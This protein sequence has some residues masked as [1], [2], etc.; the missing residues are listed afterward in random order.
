MGFSSLQLRA[1]GLAAHGVSPEQL[2]DAVAALLERGQD[3][4]A[5]QV[6]GL[7][8]SERGTA[9]DTECDRL[10]AWLSQAGAAV[11][12]PGGDDYP[13]HLSPLWPELG[14][15][16]WLFV[17]A[18][19]AHVPAGP[20]VAV[21]GSR[22][23][24]LEGRRV[25]RELGRELAVNG[26]TVVSGL[27]KGIDQ[28][29]H[30]GALD[31]EGA[32]VAVLGTGFDVDYPRGDIHLRKAI[33][34]SGGLVTEH[35]PGTPP[36]KHTFL[37]RNRIVAGLAD[38]TVV[39]EGG[40]QSGS[41]H[42]ARMAAAQGRDVWAVPGPLQAPNSQAPLALI[43]DGANVV[44]QLHDVVGAV[45]APRLELPGQ[46]ARGSVPPGNG[47]D[48]DAQTVHRL[49]SAVPSTPSAIAVAAGLPVPAVSAILA[50]L[51]DHGLAAVTP[52]GVVAV[53]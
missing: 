38:A 3:V 45:G 49:L 21:V 52:Q 40:A 43:R 41:L 2:R 10:A 30:L 22:R 20:A 51:A 32:T 31:V 27:A 42:T 5:D 19:N 28:A 15:P 39:V 4:S 36:R 34:A 24:T 1:I 29:A 12:L 26:I 16:A 9:P 25:A 17:R 7:L 46:E 47:L 14:A 48:H 6:I 11:A 8:E 35:V 13:A 44:T 53:H 23:P 18:R 37:W 50:D 33:E